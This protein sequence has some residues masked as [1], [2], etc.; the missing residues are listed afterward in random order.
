MEISIEQ[1]EYL[2]CQQRNLCREQFEIEWKRSEI[3]SEIIK[4]DPTGKIANK[5]HWVRDAIPSANIPND[6]II[7]K[8][9]HFK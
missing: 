9:Y 1:L 3:L 6:V 5:I 4:I 7:L 8:K 2:L